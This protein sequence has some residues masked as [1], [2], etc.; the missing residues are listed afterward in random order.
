MNREASARLK[1]ERG[2]ATSL[3]EAVLVIAILAIVSAIALTA[4]MNHIENAK[5]ARALADTEA[6]GISIH[7]FMNDTGFAPAFR[8]GNA[9]PGRRY[10]PGPGNRWQ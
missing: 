10:L 5:L 1:D 3:L 4:A 7:S 9:R 6:I 8:N 2:V